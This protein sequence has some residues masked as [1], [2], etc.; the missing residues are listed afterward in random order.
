[1][2][3]GVRNVNKMLEKFGGYI[4]ISGLCTGEFERYRQHVQA[5]HAHPG[6]SVGLLDK[7]TIRKSSTA[8]KN[9]DIIQAEKTTLEDVFTVPVFAVYPPGKVQQ[10]FL[11]NT[12]Q[13]FGIGV[14]RNIAGNFIDTPCCPGMYR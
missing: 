8:V 4:F 3:H 5:V 6:R 14:A 1:M 13:K 10:Q 2:M 9:P 12:L 11:E 7:C